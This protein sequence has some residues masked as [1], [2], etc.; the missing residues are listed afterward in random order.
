MHSIG[1][2]APRS[3]G[4]RSLGLSRP[5][6]SIVRSHSKAAKIPPAGQFTLLYKT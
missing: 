6:L 3:I 1:A 4:I 2:I 5:T